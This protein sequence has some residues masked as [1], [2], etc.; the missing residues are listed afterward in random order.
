MPFYVYKCKLCGVSMEEMRCMQD[1]DNTP[2]CK[3][4]GGETGRDYRGEHVNLGNREYGETKWSQAL[5]V[6]PS[7]IAEH[8]SMFPDIRVREDGCIGFDN[9]Q[10]HDRYLDKVGATKHP[11]RVKRKGK[12]IA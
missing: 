2:K 11:Q 9:Y 1:C 12:R 4:C 6:S 5:A 7:Q 10:Q 3:H 8:R